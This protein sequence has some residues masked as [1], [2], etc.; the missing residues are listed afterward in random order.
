MFFFQKLIDDT[1]NFSIAFRTKASHNPSYNK[2]YHETRDEI[3]DTKNDHYSSYY[4]HALSVY[5]RYGLLRIFYVNITLNPLV[6]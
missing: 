6:P 4:D 3:H 2:A 1:F 5:W